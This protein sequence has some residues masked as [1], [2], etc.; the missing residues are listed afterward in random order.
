MGRRVFV[1]LP[2]GGKARILTNEGN[3]RD[4]KLELGND[5]VSRILGERR[6]ADPDGKVRV[7][8]ES[9]VQVIGKKE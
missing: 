5:Y 7:P 9:S 2:G 8:I 4:G 1:W 6:Q 3:V